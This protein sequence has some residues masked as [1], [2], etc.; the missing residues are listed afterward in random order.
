MKYCAF[1]VEK[2]DTFATSVSPSRLICV[3]NQTVASISACSLT[4]KRS[5]ENHGKCG[6]CALSSR[7]ACLYALVATLQNTHSNDA[8][9]TKIFYFRLHPDKIFFAT[10]PSSDSSLYK[11]SAVVFF[12]RLIIILHPR[13]LHPRTLHCILHPRILYS[14]CHGLKFTRWTAD[15]R[16]VF[17][18]FW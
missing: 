13:I 8:R 1:D 9:I 18:F 14:S 15:V 12:Q 17:F 2:K 6:A 3:P 11:A 7:G 5:F 4:Q 10:N 16:H